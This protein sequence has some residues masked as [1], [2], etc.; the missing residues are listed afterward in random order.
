MYITIEDIKEEI[1]IL[2]KELH[3]S[4]Q[5]MLIINTSYSNKVAS[6]KSL[7]LATISHNPQISVTYSKG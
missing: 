4:Y 7:M 6:G 5:S 1:Q 2:R 3:P